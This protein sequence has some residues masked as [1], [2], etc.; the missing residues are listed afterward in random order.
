MTTPPSRDRCFN[1]P[2]PKSSH[3]PPSP[4]QRQRGHEAR[5][6]VSIGA[7]PL[8]ARRSH[9]VGAAPTVF[10]CDRSGSVGSTH[11][12]LASSLW[13]TEVRDWECGDG[14]GCGADRPTV[15]GA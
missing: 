10:R 11:P 3:R 15:A 14:H 1:P 2:R 9:V 5:D 13:G 6:V 7:W 4:P 8:C 12:G